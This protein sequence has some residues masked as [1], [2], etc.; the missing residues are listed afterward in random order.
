LDLAFFIY[1][2]DEGLIRR[3]EIKAHNVPD[4]FDKEGIGGELKMTLAMGL[5]TKGTPKTMD[6]GFGDSGGVRESA[7]TPVGTAVRFGLKSSLDGGSYPVI[8]NGAGPSRPEFIMKPLNTLFKEASSP[9]SNRRQ[10]QTQFLGDNVIVLAFGG[11]E[12]DLGAVNQSGGQGTRLA[13][14]LKLPLFFLRKFNHG[15]GTSSVQGY[16][17]FFLL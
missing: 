4:F 15:F 11:P 3:I 5:N 17:P 12:H 10:R 6:C 14:S 16:P 2:E 8:S 9:L 13:E 7:A 1:A